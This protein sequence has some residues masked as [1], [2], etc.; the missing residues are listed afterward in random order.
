MIARRP[1]PMYFLNVCRTYVALPMCE[2]KFIY[3]IHCD[4]NIQRKYRKIK[5]YYALKT[6][7]FVQ[8]FVFKFILI[9]K[10]CNGYTLYVFY[11]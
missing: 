11:F 5:K 8:T 7:F 6:F 9:T 10:I 4:A 1:R 3:L 2:A